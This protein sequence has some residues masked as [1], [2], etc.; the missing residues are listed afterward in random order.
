LARSDELVDELLGSQAAPSLETGPGIAGITSG[1]GG[2]SWDAFGSATA[3][4][5]EGDRIAFVTLDDGTV[6]VEDDQPDGALDPLADVIEEMAQP[7]YRAAAVRSDG[8]VWTV[9]AEKIELAELPGIGGDVVDLSVVGGSRELQIDGAPAGDD[10]P[11]LDAI[12]DGR[13][14]VALHAERVD[15]DVFAV[16][17][18]PL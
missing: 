11:A 3:P 15:G 6:L 4:A 12:A 14:D 13:G 2:R 9:V 7:P 16:D 8:D 1:V 17:V 5:L 18:F 10:V